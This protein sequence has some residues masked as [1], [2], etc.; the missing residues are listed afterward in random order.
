MLLI[1]LAPSACTLES[2]L[3]DLFIFYG[4][5]H[6]YRCHTLLVNVLTPHQGRHE[7]RVNAAG[8]FFWSIITTN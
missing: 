1:R 2:L 5:V 4:T 3:K 7:Q 6:I 8:I